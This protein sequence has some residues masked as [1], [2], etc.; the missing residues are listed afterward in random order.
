MNV[1]P[2]INLLKYIS[3]ALLTFALLTAYE[4]STNGIMIAGEYRVYYL[5]DI[6]DFI[7][8]LF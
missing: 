1:I 2:M 5:A 3:V 8:D 6:F 4:L 7:R